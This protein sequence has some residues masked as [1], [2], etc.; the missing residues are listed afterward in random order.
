MLALFFSDYARDR[1]RTASKF[2]ED[3]N[4]KKA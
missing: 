2:V 4:L 1:R 3:G